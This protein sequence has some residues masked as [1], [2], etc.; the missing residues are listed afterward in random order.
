MESAHQYVEAA[1]TAIQL[2][3]FIRNLG[4]DARAHIDGNYQV[5][6]PLVARDAGL[7]EI[8]RMSLL[9]TPKHGPRVRLAVVTTNMPFYQIHI[10][11]ITPY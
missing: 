10:H 2:A 3:A 4:Y 1:R 9:I 11:Q 8:G 5:I 7:G 6:A